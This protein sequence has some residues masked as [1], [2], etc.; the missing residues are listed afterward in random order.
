MEGNQK[1]LL[2]LGVAAIGVIFLAMRNSS[3][4]SPVSV[5]RSDPNA[6]G[7]AQ[8]QAQTQSENTSAR[9]TAFSKLTDTL[10]NFK[11]QALDDAFNRDSLASNE[12]LQLEALKV[13]S[14]TNR[15]ARKLAEEQ[16][17]TA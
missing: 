8:L 17:S 6:L 3:S 9:V 14:K 16:L 7:I 11:Q 2:I 10:V 4:A 1:H 12:R 5:T 13:Q 15:Q